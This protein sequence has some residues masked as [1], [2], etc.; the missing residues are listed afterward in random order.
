MFARK[1]LLIGTF[2]L[3][4]AG[5]LLTLRYAK[6]LSVY[7][8]QNADVLNTKDQSSLLL[9]PNKTLKETVTQEMF[10]D[11]TLQKAQETVLRVNA[12]VEILFQE[13]NPEPGESV[14]PEFSA[15]IDEIRIEEYGFGI[16]FINETLVDIYLEENPKPDSAIGVDYSSL[17]LAYL[18]ITY[19]FP[20]E[21]EERHLQIFRERVK[22]QN[23]DIFIFGE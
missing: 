18:A 12:R 10:K 22:E 17:V 8:D 19:Q 14:P 3:L 15:E 1:V 11:S 5:F 13:F 2:F 7:E 20:E 21:D 23:F 4:I 6:I 9:P 16:E